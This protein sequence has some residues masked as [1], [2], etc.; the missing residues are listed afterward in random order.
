M[1]TQE[2]HQTLKNTLLQSKELAMDAKSLLAI[3]DTQLGIRIDILDQFASLADK[4]HFESKITKE[5]ESWNSDHKFYI[6][7]K[8]SPELQAKRTDYK[9]LLTKSRDPFGLQRKLQSIPGVKK[10]IAVCSGKGGVGK[11]TVAAN[12]AAFLAASNK[13][14]GLVDADIYGPSQAMIF[15]LGPENHPS[16]G[17]NSKIRAPAAHQ[18]QIMS[19]GILGSPSQPLVWRGPMISKA[20]KQLCFD[21]EW[22][23]LDYLI[24][25]L[26]P[27]TGDVQLTMLESLQVDSAIIV[28]TPQGIALL[29]VQKAVT[30]FQTLKLPILGVIENM[31]VYQ[32]RNCGSIDHIFGSSM[33]EQYC[34]EQSISYLGVLPLQSDISLDSDVGVPSVLHRDNIRRSFYEF[35]QKCG[36]L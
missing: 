5:L 29:D 21:V 11:S 10:I 34:L 25:D 32:C 3:Q 20:F 27:G 7:F 33:V 28:S 13:K 12:L 16:V 15:G 35:S 26:P 18:V 4:I 24:L 9:P 14:V 2:L 36:L 1:N 30:M 6:N 8:K 19:F 22:G 31:A 17:V 23:E